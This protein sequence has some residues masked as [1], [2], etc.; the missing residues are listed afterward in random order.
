MKRSILNILSIIVV[1]VSFAF[2]TPTFEGI[3]SFG[4]CSDDP[5]NIV[6]S[7]NGDQTFSYSDHSMSPAIDVTGTWSL[8]KNGTVVLVSDSELAFHDKWKISEDGMTATSRYG[9]SFY[10][11]KR[12]K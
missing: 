10:T 3:G 1:S 5:S 4:V 6:L 2:N 12:M 9:L 7:I 8:K 11:L